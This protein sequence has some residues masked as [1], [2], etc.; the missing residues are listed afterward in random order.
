MNSQVSSALPSA[1]RFEFGEQ[2]DTGH[3]SV[4][5]KCQG[6]ILWLYLHVLSL[7]CVWHSHAVSDPFYWLNVSGQGLVANKCALY[8]LGQLVTEP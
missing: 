6:T 5:D 7:I 4:C 1:A 2:F 3:K 8:W